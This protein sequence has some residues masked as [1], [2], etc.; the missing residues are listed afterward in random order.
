[1]SAETCRYFRSKIMFLP[2]SP[3]EGCPD[4]ERQGAGYCW[5]NLTMTQL[6][7]DDR[8]VSYEDC[9]N[10]GRRCYRPTG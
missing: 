6:G 3:D 4:G 5:C 2:P 8:V 10:S 7:E 9:A 1:M